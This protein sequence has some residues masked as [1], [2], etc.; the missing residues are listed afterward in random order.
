M[1]FQAPHFVLNWYAAYRSEWRPVIVRC[2][3]STGQ[4][5][6][7]WLLAHH[8]ATGVLAHAGVHQAEYHAWLALP[9]HDAEF[10]A[11]AWCELRRRVRFRTLQFKYLAAAS[12]AD[13]LRGMGELEGCL[14]VRAHSRPLAELDLREGDGVSLKR[15]KKSKQTRFNR[16]KKLGNV[17]FQRL[18]DPEDLN[19]LFKDFE[20]LYDFRQGAVNRS[21]PFFD[22]PVKWGFHQA[23][24][25]A[26]PDQI[27]V[28]VTTLN[29][30]TI[31]A[32][33]GILS[34]KTL[35]VGMLAHLPQLAEHSPGKLHVLQLIDYLRDE[36]MELLD[37][38]PGGDP[39]KE[40]FATTHDEV[41]EILLYRSPWLR[42]RD[43]LVEVMRL[44]IKRAL[45][46]VGISPA[47]LRTLWER[48]RRVRPES[49]FRK[50]VHWAIGKRELRVY[51]VDRMF[52]DRF[53]SDP[54]VQRD[55]L[56]DLLCFV[57]A[58]AWQSR[59]AFLSRALARIEGGESAYTISVGGSLA[60][61]GWVTRQ[62]RS[63]STEVEQVIE[64]PEGSVALYD[65]YTHP[66]MRGR[67]FYRSVI[68][69]M[70]RDV[71]SDPS[72]GYAYISVLADN[73]ASRHVVES[74]G[75]EYQGSLYWESRFGRQRKW[76]G[77]VRNPLEPLHA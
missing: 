15:S 50:I 68:E 30:S 21:T 44:A 75:F 67:G 3:D 55:S 11:E 23:V 48:T 7:L 76:A 74:V 34:G 53:A 66:D 65:F 41:W 5:V 54:R 39:W 22:D 25:A 52:M 61:S 45:A 36:G 24:F 42:T 58:E 13:T 49:I 27:H 57:P 35:H 8:P 14:T 20:S 77:P 70:L 37:L 51:R 32:L 64:F 62:N 28:T 69:Q 6:G 17:E 18:T 9:G 46:L 38:T 2:S 60:T 16:L 72:V 73:F 29:G 4:L 40:R 31:A 47:D 12:L 63:Y 10:V 19:H 1:I 43:Q 33:W 71:F 56:R 59:D 26:A